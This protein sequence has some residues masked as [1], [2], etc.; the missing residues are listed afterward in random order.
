MKV[1]IYHVIRNDAGFLET[2]KI[3]VFT[4]VESFSLDDLSYC[5]NG[6]WL[7][8][9]PYNKNPLY[10]QLCDHDEFEVEND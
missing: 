5:D 10:I 9:K 3:E 7:V 2:D 8:I 1:I 4:N 6:K